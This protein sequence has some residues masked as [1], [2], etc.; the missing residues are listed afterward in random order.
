LPKL[1]EIV[2]FFFPLRCR[3]CGEYLCPSN[4]TEIC[5]DCWADVKDTP[6]TGCYKCDWSI[7]V[8][9]TDELAE[10]LICGQCKNYSD[11]VDRISSYGVYDGVLKE[12]IQLFKYG[13]N[14]FT[15]ER[16]SSLALEA[17]E[18]RFSR[19][20]FDFIVPVPL[21]RS[22][23]RWREFNQALILSEKIKDEY[24]IPITYDLLKRRKK[25]KSQTELTVDQRIDNMKNAFTLSRSGRSFLSL[26]FPK[27]NPSR[28]SKEGMDLKGKKVLLVDD[29]LTTGITTNECAKVLKAA[30]VVFIGVVTVAKAMH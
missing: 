9:S 20:D 16:L 14:I 22:R 18:R 19:L 10:S 29:V 21:H 25:T 27:V 26:L 28:K 30:G 6:S 4:C 5:D 11:K 15:G 2:N 23:L 13:R 8:G 7:P 3:I 1:R 17:F 24:K 12:A